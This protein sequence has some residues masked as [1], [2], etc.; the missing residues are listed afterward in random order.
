[1]MVRQTLRPV[2]RELRSVRHR[3]YYSLTAT[4]C[5]Q[6]GRDRVIVVISTEI[7]LSIYQQLDDYL[8]FGIPY[9]FDPTELTSIEIQGF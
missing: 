9:V 3:Y 5:I 4:E 6:P 2:S 1:M 7:N 8:V